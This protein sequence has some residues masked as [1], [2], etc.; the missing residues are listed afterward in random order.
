MLWSACVF[1]RALQCC[2]CVSACLSMC[3][4]WVE[5]SHY[6]VVAHSSVSHPAPQEWIWLLANGPHPPRFTTGDNLTQL[7]SDALPVSHTSLPSPTGGVSRM[8]SEPQDVC[9]LPARYCRIFLCML[10]WLLVVQRFDRVNVLVCI[11]VWG[12]MMP[13]WLLIQDISHQKRTTETLVLVP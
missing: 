13:A 11:S 10:V 6:A 8:Q 9:A 7:C 5:V 3:Q 12:Y 2:K 1:V 4:C